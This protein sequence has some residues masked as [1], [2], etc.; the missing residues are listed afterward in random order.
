MADLTEAID[1][2]RVKEVFASGTAVTI[3]PV[4]EILYQ[5]K[6]YTIP[7][8]DGTAGENTRLLTNAMFDIQVSQGQPL[9]DSTIHPL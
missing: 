8:A 3:C 4:K 1:D 7:I 2:G 6:M 9:C 5:D